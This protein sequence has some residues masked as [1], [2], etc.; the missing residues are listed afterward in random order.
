[1]FSALV[2]LVA[3]VVEEIDTEARTEDNKSS[4]VTDENDAVDVG[5]A[6]ARSSILKDSTLLED[7]LE[8]Y[9]TDS[10]EAFYDR[11]N[12]RGKKKKTTVNRRQILCL[13]VGGYVRCRTFSYWQ[14][15]FKRILSG[16]LTDLCG[17]IFAAPCKIKICLAK[18]TK[19]KTGKTIFFC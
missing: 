3:T 9:A 4:K 2:T 7:L 6:P 17:R 13:L 12:K 1:M 19:K 11:V 5:V 8:S 15:L 14:E 18:P 16:R 10:S